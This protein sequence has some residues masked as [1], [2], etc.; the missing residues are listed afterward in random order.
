MS[1]ASDPVHAYD[2]AAGEVG[3]VDAVRHPDRGLHE[4]GDV[5]L[6]ETGA[7]QR[8]GREDGAGALGEGARG[9]AGVTV[10]LHESHVAWASYERAL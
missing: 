8:A 4:L 6:P 7:A 2:A 9:L 5:A 3:Q 1:R 10:T